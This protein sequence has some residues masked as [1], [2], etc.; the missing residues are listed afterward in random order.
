MKLYIRNM[1]S[2]HSRTM[3]EE[4]LNRLGLDHLPAESGE[5]ELTGEISSSAVILL[6]E[7]LTRNE[8]ELIEDKKIQLIEKIKHSILE[9][10]HDADKPLKTNF[11]NYLSSRLMYDYTYMAN[12]FSRIQGITIEHYIILLK[13]ERVKELLADSQLTIKEISYKLHYSSVAHLSNQFKKVTGF[14]LKHFKQ[15]GNKQL[16]LL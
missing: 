14:T 8:L 3:V 16:L 11:S 10:V 5:V 6:K 13:I 15:L 4:E 9:I 1:V 12:L 7:F 2:L